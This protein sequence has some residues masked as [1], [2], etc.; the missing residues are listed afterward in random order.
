MARVVKDVVLG[1]DIIEGRDDAHKKMIKVMEENIKASK[2]LET[3]WVKRTTKTPEELAELVASTAKN[4][5][6]RFKRLDT[7]AAN[8]T[9]SDWAEF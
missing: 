3:L 7:W 2:R 5:G 4:N 6:V 8:Y 9:D 1:Y